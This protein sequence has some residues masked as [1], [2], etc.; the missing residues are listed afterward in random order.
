MP[1]LL[2]VDDEIDVCEFAR[3]FFRKRQIDVFVATGGRQALDLI[4]EM[5]FELILLDV[6]MGE[7][8][9]IEVLEELR[10]KNIRVKVIMV[11]GVVDTEVINEAK[12][13]GAINFINKPFIIEELE[14]MVL[15]ELNIKAYIK[16]GGG[17]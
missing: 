12:R 4:E 16:G 1:S 3:N 11:S 7:M 9:G 13:L 5:K 10:T 6:R 8:N 14:E 15:C 17:I 2:I